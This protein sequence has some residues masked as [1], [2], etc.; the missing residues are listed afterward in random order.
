MKRAAIKIKAEKYLKILCLK[1][2][3]RCPGR[4]NNIKAL[5]FFE[6]VLS[7]YGWKIKRQNFN[8]I[9]WKENKV[10]L[11]AGNTF[12]KARVSPYSKSCRVKAPLT[13]VSS[14]RELRNA[15]LKGRIVLLKGEITAQ[16][17]MPKKFVFY[18]PDEHKEIYRLLVEKKPAAIITA[19]SKNPETAGSAYPF[20]MI[21]DGDFNIPSVYMKDIYGKKLALFENSIISLSFKSERKKSKA[22]NVAGYKGGAGNKIT[23]CAHIDTKDK[24]P[25]ALD[26]GT[27][28]VTLM[29][30]AEMM[31]NYT[32]KNRLEILAL[33][34]EDFY[35]VPGQM[36]YLK[37]N[38]N[39]MDKIRFVI[40]MDAAGMKGK[41]TAFSF[42]GMQ[43]ADAVKIRRV[44][45]DAPGF[46]EGSQWPQG[47]HMVFA[48]FGVPAVAITSENFTQL[49]SE[50]THTDKDK[51][52]LVDYKKLVD[53]AE[54]LKKM[55]EEM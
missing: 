50:I 44:F 25:G 9:T 3:E 28:I 18:N 35:A 31:K 14:L 54:T 26:N 34:G 32:G 42:Y 6:K 43:G 20:P 16:Q 33:N 12:F 47:D 30:L 37:V 40:N 36:K 8:C 53:I 4:K 51:P 45:S 29:L 27:G 2:P 39:K 48:S 1:M 22:W 46:V 38:N 10:I 17:L 7:S 23:V 5:L 52:S 41:K 15:D 21:E 55:I 13:V 49:C 19:T 11:K 24:T